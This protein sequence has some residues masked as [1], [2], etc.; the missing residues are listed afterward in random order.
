MSDDELA[1]E[2]AAVEAVYQQDNLTLREGNISLNVLHQ[3]PVRLQML[4]PSGYPSECPVFLLESN[5][6]AVEARRE[7][8]CTLLHSVWVESEGEP[9]ALACIDA[10]R[11]ALADLELMGDLAG[12]DVT[13][14]EAPDDLAGDVP[15]TVMQP[16]ADCG[17]TFFPAYP[18]YG[19]V[20]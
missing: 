1:D 2:L 13:A 15:E 8:L 7:Q 19:Q 11:D 20:S 14:P 6:R 9:C 17:W 10:C 12:E 4:L 16:T 3:P 5:S 18:K